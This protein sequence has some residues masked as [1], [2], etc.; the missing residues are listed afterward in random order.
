MSYEYCPIIG[1]LFYKPSAPSVPYPLFPDVL[2][3]M[4]YCV[5]ECQCPDTNAHYCSECYT[6]GGSSFHG[7]CLQ[8]PCI[9]DP[10]LITASI[11]SQI[12]NVVEILPTPV[13]KKTFEVV[14]PK[15]RRDIG[16]KE[17]AG[18]HYKALYRAGLLLETKRTYKVPRHKPLEYAPSV[19][20]VSL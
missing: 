12:D 15:S 8:D 18:S 5:G 9:Q 1:D 20:S 3:F 19:P 17:R 13:V 2:S 11:V 4:C 6:L 14:R 7:P 10:F 16:K